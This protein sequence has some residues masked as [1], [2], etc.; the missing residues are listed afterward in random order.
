MNLLY[1]YD[2]KVEKR[3]SPTTL[4]IK[5]R[6]AAEKKVKQGHPWIF[7][8]GI[9]SVNKEGRAGDLA[10]IF[11]KQR[12]QCIGVGLYDPASPIRIKLLHSGGPQKIDAAF[13]AERI[14]AARSLRSPLLTTNT[15]SYRLIFGEN[16]GL[17][18]LIADVYAGVLVVKLYSAI[19]R[20]YLR[21]LT[22]ILLEQSG[23]ET[24]VLRLSRRLQ[25]DPD[26]PAELPDGTVLAGELVDP[27]VIF[28]EHG[29]RFSANVIRGHKTG[30]FLD[31][32]HNRWRVQQ[33]AAGKRVLDVFAYAGGFSVHALVGGATQ[34]CSVDISA[35]ALE[36]ARANAALNPHT[37]QHET[38][39]GDAFVQLAAFAKAGRHFDIVIVDPPAFAKK[40][41]EV[42]AALQ[43]Y[44]RLCRLAIP[45]V[46][47]N[48]LLL[49]ASCS[50]RV[51]PLDFFTEVE[52]ELQRSGRSW[53]KEAETGHDIDHPVG[54]PE[55][56]YLKTGYYRLDSGKNNLPRR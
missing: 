26:W 42:P 15:N 36:L 29:L 31:H 4:A 37:G 56:R 13:F 51:S 28:R 5:L 40:A 45:L 33:R 8:Q 23:A 20:P 22:P 55:G 44:G 11:D 34:V 10:I 2:M 30:Y 38:Q 9:A 48:G 35:Q 41:S 49:M 32:R 53:Q 21:D 1:I 3:F 18:G 46:A 12:N 43:Q 47:P 14:K 7:E 50:S 39:A 16:D 27:T 54:F 19:W 6:P 25:H 52:K 17:P 24:L